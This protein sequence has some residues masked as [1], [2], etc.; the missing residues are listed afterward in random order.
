MLFLDLFYKK[1]VWKKKLEK[2]ARKKIE[3]YAS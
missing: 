1:N 3:V 2:K